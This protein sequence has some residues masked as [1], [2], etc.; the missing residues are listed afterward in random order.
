[1]WLWLMCDIILNH[2][3]RLKNLKYKNENKNKIKSNFCNS[4]IILVVDKC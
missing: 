4:D 3:L 2:N 1:M